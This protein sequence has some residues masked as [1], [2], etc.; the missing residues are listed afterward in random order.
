M[1]AIGGSYEYGWDVP[2]DHAEAVKWYLK[3]AEEGDADA[4]VS[5]AD[6]YFVENDTEAVKWYRKATR[7]GN[8]EAQFSLGLACEYGRGMPR[9][10]AEAAKWY[11]KA[12]EQGVASA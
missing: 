12:A 1:T 4:Q 3:A 9:N 5:L 8:A 11:H 10:Y 7:Q 6:M 2:R